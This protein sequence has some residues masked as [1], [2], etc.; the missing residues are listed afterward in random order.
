MLS[1]SD[2]NIAAWGSASSQ[3]TSASFASTPPD[4]LLTTTPLSQNAGAN[5]ARSL[6]ASGGR[7]RA[8]SLAQ[9]STRATGTTIV[10][11]RAHGASVAEGEHEAMVTRYEDLPSAMY[12]LEEQLHRATAQLMNL[13]RRACVIKMEGQ[14]PFLTRTPD[15]APAFK[16]TEFKAEILPRYIEATARRSPYLVPADTVDDELAARAQQLT[17]PPTP[18][19][20]DFAAPEPTPTILDAPDA[21]ARDFHK[22][23]GKPKTP[24]SPASGHPRR[25]RFRVIDGGADDGENPK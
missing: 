9:H 16:S 7:S 2:A 4:A 5:S 17:A 11:A 18:P 13:P 10:R 14:A 19:E 3:G 6:S 23:R 22:R 21:Y 20:P 24:K 8:R 15:L 25:D 12:T 1:S